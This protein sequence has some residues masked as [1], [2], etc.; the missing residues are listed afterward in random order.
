MAAEEFNRSISDRVLHI[1]LLL[2]TIRRA[3]K[4]ND[5]PADEAGMHAT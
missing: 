5:P 1:L 3:E 2:G 4:P